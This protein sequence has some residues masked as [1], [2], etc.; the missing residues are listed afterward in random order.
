MKWAMFGPCINN[1]GYI[2]TYTNDKELIPFVEMLWKHVP[3]IYM[4]NKPKVRRIVCEWKG[5]QVT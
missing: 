2:Y 5:K 3:N 1:N 4:I